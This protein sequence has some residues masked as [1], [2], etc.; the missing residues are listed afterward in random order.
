MGGEIEQHITTKTG[1]TEN[2]KGCRRV[3][4]VIREQVSTVT[5][6]HGQNIHKKR[7]SLFLIL[8]RKDALQ[9]NLDKYLFNIFTVFGQYTFEGGG[10]YH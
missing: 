3:Q 8:A 2:Q 7:Y 9:L 1:N 10:V 6:C 5:G 4:P